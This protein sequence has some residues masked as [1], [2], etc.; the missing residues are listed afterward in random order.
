[1]GT[2]ESALIATR[3]DRRREELGITVQALAVHADIPRSTLQ[4]RLAGNGKPFDIAE[5]S[6]MSATLDQPISAWTEGL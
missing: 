4:R 6:R 1:M 2:N 3:I 5:L